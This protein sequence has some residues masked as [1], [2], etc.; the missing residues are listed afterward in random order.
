MTGNPGESLPTT[1]QREII[2]LSNHGREISMCNHVQMQ[3]VMH[4]I[5]KVFELSVILFVY[6]IILF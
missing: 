2:P 4:W 1:Q 3:N 5:A 6:D